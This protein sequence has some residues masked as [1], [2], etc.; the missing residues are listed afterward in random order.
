MERRLTEGPVENFDVAIAKVWKEPTYSW[1]G[2]VSNIIA[3]NGGVGVTLKEII[4]TF[5]ANIKGF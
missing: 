5:E 4:T 3:P 2:G 1:Q